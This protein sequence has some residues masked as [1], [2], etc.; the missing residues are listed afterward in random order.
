MKRIL[1][2]VF[3]AGMSM[4]AFCT[5]HII[6]T[7]GFVFS[8]A[9]INIQQGD[10]V[11]FNIGGIHRVEEVTEATW[12]ANGATPK[13]GFNTPFG[14]GLILPAQLAEGTHWYVCV[15]HAA[16]GMKGKIVVAGT[17]SIRNQPTASVFN[18]F[19]NPSNGKFQLEMEQAAN[20]SNYQMD[21]I[22]NEG[23]KVYAVR[24][25]E[26]RSLNEID[27]TTFGTGIYFVRVYD[28]SGIYTRKIVVQ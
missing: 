4:T 8:P 18:L 27:L 5:I 24:N 7:P 23:R 26:Q 9:T 2:S 21:I 25:L 16:D 20:T 12:N 19:P 6:T 1:L 13:P 10:S 14:G 22:N 17:T 3:L 28:G 15:P 11:R